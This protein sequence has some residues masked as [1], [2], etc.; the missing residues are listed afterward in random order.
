MN[1][2]IIGASG[3]AG[4]EL[5]RLLAVHPEIEVIASGA[6]SHAGERIS[7]LY[8]SLLPFY[9]EKQ[10][11]DSDKL[12]SDLVSGEVKA[13]VVFMALPHGVS[14]SI[15]PQIYDKVALIVDLSADFRLKD[16]AA[17]PVWYQTPHLAPQY[18]EAAVYGLPELTRAD[19]KGAKLIAA[20]GCY[21]TCSTLPLFPLVSKGLIESHSIIVDAASGVT[22]A[23]RSLRA[24]LLFAEVDEDFS[25][26]GLKNHRHTPEIEQNLNAQV[27]FSPHLAPMNRGILATTYSKPT[28]KLLER[29]AG[30]GAAG[31]SG[32][33][34]L[35]EVLGSFYSGEPFVHVTDVPPS[36]KAT[37]GSNNAMI[38][39]TY[40]PRT[41]TVITVSAID[42][43][44]KGASGQ[45][46]QCANVALGLPEVAGLASLGLYP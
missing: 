13:D 9:G 6:S 12:V 43:L 17:Y 4:A 8:P 30:S 18:L 19:L 20:A 34:V 5:L 35:F 28:Q 29:I 10:F 40:D 44:I 27:L 14:Q 25:A 21:V 2:A 38:F 24:N 36:T 3:Y 23:G 7:T 39:G 1:S 33:H 26:Y 37:L 42:N 11:V 31:D 45:A 41:S 46:I 16:P 15:V 32:S 22:G